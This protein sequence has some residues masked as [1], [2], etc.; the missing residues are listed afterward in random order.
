MIAEMFCHL[1]I[2]KRH[3]TYAE[4]DF[5]MNR[6][7]VENYVHL[8]THWIHLFLHKSEE[9]HCVIVVILDT[10]IPRTFGMIV[11]Y[12][13]P[14]KYKTSFQGDHCQFL[15]LC[16]KIQYK[17]L[18][19]AVSQL[20]QEKIFKCYVFVTTI[21]FRGIK[22]LVRNKNNVLKNI[23]LLTTQ[24]CRWPHKM[25][26]LKSLL[27]FIFFAKSLVK[28][29]FLYQSYYEAN[30]GCLPVRLLLTMRRLEL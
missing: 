26:I 28:G 12:Q 1:Y 6:L 25:W 30:S 16:L 20:V 7:N 23:M 19:K 2:D 29:I 18:Y 3:T 21:P 15:S 17:G 8:Y 9:F 11:F 4:V 22:S 27:W 5:E 24:L 14:L 10:H 13:V